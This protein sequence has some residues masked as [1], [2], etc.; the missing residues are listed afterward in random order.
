MF[1]S[2]IQKRRS[3]R[4]YQDRSVESE[5]VDLLVEAALRPPSSKGNRPWEFVVVTDRGLL[6]GLARAK[7]HGSAFL[8][9][10]PLGIV[11][12]A[13]PEKSDVWVEDAAIASTFLLLTAESLG[14][15]ACWIQIRERMHS[16][17]RSSQAYIADLL[18]LPQGMT[19]QSII[20]VGYPDESKAPRGKDELAYERVHLNGYGRPYDRPR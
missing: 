7:V 9:D 4:K 19:V 18:G 6:E 12:C 10:A 17:G 14:L 13:R 8:K 3:I 11:V 5:K 15:G 2:L 16:E 1:L 20:A